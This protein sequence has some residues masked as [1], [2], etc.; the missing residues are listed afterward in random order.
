MGNRED[1]NLDKHSVPHSK[2]LTETGV[3]KMVQS[4][5]PLGLPLLTPNLDLGTKVPQPPISRRERERQTGCRVD[6]KFTYIASH[7]EVDYRPTSEAPGNT[8]KDDHPA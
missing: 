4:S 8:K 1:I 2:P 7:S 5:G 3:E 6:S